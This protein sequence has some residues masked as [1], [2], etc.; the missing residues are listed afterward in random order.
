M[1]LAGLLA[2]WPL[3][4]AAEEG[5]PVPGVRLGAVIKWV[6]TN[7]ERHEKTGIEAVS[8]VGLRWVE[9]GVHGELGDGVGYRIDLAAGSGIYRDP[10][11]GVGTI[12]AAGGPG[13]FGAVGVRRAEMEFCG[14]I[15]KTCLTTGI[16]VPRWGLFHQ[17]PT[18]DWELVDL[19]LIYTSPAFKNIGWHNTGISI[20]ATPLDQIELGLFAIN[21]YFPGGQANGEPFLPSGERDREKAMGGSLLLWSGP[22]S[23]F[24]GVLD[25]GWQEDLRGGP[26]AERQHALAWIAG[27]ELKTEKAWAA[28]E[29]SDLIIEEY[30]LR[31]DGRWVD[32]RSMGG[33]ADFGW[34]LLDD[35]QALIR[36]EWIDPNTADTEKTFS[37]SRFDQVAQW[38]FGVNYRFA[39]GALFMV[40]YVTPIEEGSGVDVDAGKLGGEYQDVKNDYFRIQVQV[41]Q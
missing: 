35:W 32:L 30:Q 36:W 1:S 24:G 5:A 15:P 19:P 41:W 22:V 39:P 21:G 23:I 38:T 10:I 6:Y 3:A 18:Y 27:A 13:E 2:A 28:I 4:L 25:E 33:H 12:A 40:N 20:V 14:L 11:T 26:G 29:W 16:F 8:E 7:R 31:L 17:R 34:W 9:L 37:R